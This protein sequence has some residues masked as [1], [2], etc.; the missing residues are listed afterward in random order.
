MTNLNP[1]ILIYIE[2]LF[3][4]FSTQ[5]EV[6]SNTCSSKSSNSSFSSE[7]GSLFNCFRYSHVMFVLHAQIYFFAIGYCLSSNRGQSFY[8]YFFSNQFFNYR[9]SCTCRMLKLNSTM[10]CKLRIPLLD[11]TFTCM[12]LFQQGS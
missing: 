8:L 5:M 7:I 11:L 10:G 3:I 9:L 12:H 1:Q 6:T 4:S 2:G